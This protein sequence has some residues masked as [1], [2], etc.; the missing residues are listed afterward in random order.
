[1]KFSLL[2]YLNL[3]FEKGISIAY[4]LYS[5]GSLNSAFHFMGWQDNSKIIKIRQIA[6]LKNSNR[7]ILL[8]ILLILFSCTGNKSKDK[9]LLLSLLSNSENSVKAYFS[10]PGRFTDTVKKREVIESIL[11]IINS[12]EYSLQIYA[13]SFNNPEM[14]SALKEAKKRGV[15]IEIV[16]DKDHTYELLKENGFTIKDWKQSGLHHI[17]VILADN[18]T[19][20][21]GTGNFSRQGLTNDWNGYI[22]LDVDKINRSNTLDFLNENYKLPVLDTNGISFI[23]SPENGYLSQNILL[24]KVESAKVSI[25]FLI[26]DHFDGVL[27]HALRKASE[28]GVKVTGVYDAPVDEE[29]EYLADNFYGVSSEIYKDGNEDIVETG[30]FPEGGLLHHKS[31]IIDGKILL[32][33]SYNYSTNAKDSNREILFYTENRNL[34]QDFQKEFYRVKEKSYPVPKLKLY[35]FANK[36]ILDTGSISGNTLCLPDNINSPT[37]ELGKGIW[38][39]YLYYPKIKNTK[40]ISLGNY[41]NISSGLTHAS[42]SDFFSLDSIW[43]SYQVYDRDS[44][45]SYHF[46]SKTQDPLFYSDKLIIPKNPLYLS[47]TSSRVYFEMKEFLPIVGRNIYFWIPGKEIRKSKIEQIPESKAG[48]TAIIPTTSSERFYAGVWIESEDVF[49]FFCYQERTRANRN[50]FDFILNQLYLDGGR[51][52]AEG[53]ACIKND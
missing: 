1:L 52:N 37:I 12:A 18:K 32:S 31:M 33:G 34:V 27:S 41:E 8:V 42:K 11:N 4:A 21:T 7:L 48:Y 24:E 15:K 51:K 19:L 3:Y 47:F 5:L 13:Y 30:S 35:T 53:Q 25:D 14:I 16:G 26:F 2:T 39:S 44:N 50:S 43:D 22:Q 29:G 38:K 6:N 46:N 20:F 45:I 28:R 9:R 23:S 17:K 40:C 49:Y 10:Y 36:K